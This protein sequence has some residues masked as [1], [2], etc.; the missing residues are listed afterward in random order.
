MGTLAEAF[1]SKRGAGFV[2]IENPWATMAIDMTVRVAARVIT[3]RVSVCAAKLDVGGACMVV[4]VHRPKDDYG[5][6][7]SARVRRLPDRFRVSRHC[8]SPEEPSRLSATRRCGA[9]S[10]RPDA[11]TAR[12]SGV[13]PDEPR[14]GYRH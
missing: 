12:S 13:R 3:N 1:H 7:A 9:D 8:R 2:P 14:A 10:L 4:V 5:C 11:H 6:A